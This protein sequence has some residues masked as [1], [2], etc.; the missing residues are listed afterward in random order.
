MNLRTLCVATLATLAALASSA[1]LAVSPTSV[2]FSHGMQGWVGSGAG[3]NTFSGIDTSLGNGTPSF[4]AIGPASGFQIEN[5][6]NAAFLGNFTAM[7]SL[8]FSMDV[9]VA[10]LAI[11]GPGGWPLAQDLVLEFRDY[12]KRGPELPYSSV[13]IRMG[14]IGGDQPASQH[15]SVTIADTSSS[16]LPTGWHGSGA[17]DPYYG[18]PVLPYGQSFSRILSDV[19]SVVVSTYLPGYIYGA[20]QFYNLSVDNIAIAAVP[21]PEQAAMLGAGLGLI[22]WVSRRRKRQ[23]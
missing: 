7:K 20:E 6:T 4:H 23:A 21:E 15:F 22:G 8:T 12:D 5:K 10:E 16:T 9:N 17:M 14:M 11:G 18:E 2:D 19:D 1:A 13:W 3:G